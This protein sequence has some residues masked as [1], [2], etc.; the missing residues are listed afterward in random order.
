MRK[1]QEIERDID[2][3]QP[4]DRNWLALDRLLSELWETGEP[5]KALRTLFN[6]FERFPEEDGAGVFWTIVHG[7][8]SFD[9]YEKELLDSLTRQPSEFG[10]LMA[11]RIFNTGTKKICDI[12]KENLISNLLNHSGTSEL[13]K[14]Q[15]KG[16]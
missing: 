16:L 8:E 4:L 11:K 1:L 7:V 10:L 9:G 12:G 6:I 15:V 14:Q 13:L 5:E 2:N 3:F